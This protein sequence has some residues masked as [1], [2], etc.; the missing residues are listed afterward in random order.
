[1]SWIVLLAGVALWWAAHLFKRV[2]PA[3]RA[4]LGDKAKGYVALALGVSV[5]L[6]VLG[7]RATPFVALWTPPAFLTHVNNLLMLAAFYLMS[8]A[9]K[10]GLFLTGMR[11]PMLT[12]F[13]L[14]ALSHLLV[15]GD[16]ASVLMFGGLFVWVPVAMAAINRAL[17]DWTPNPRGSA[18]YEA[19]GLVGAVLLMGVIGM[20]HGWLGPWPFGGGA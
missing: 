4:A 7:Y 1:M 11:H 17:P 16:L 20:I 9:P 6:M 19:M 2:S 14:W 10:K 3:S 8:P 5:V 18:K 12:G 13:G 15:N